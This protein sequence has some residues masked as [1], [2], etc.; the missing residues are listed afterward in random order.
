MFSKFT[1]MLDTKKI[2]NGNDLIKNIYY[3]KRENNVHRENAIT[4]SCLG[5]LMSTNGLELDKWKKDIDRLIREAVKE[6][7]VSHCPLIIGLAESGIVPSALFHQALREQQIQADWV[8]ST[9]RPSHG[10]HFS[11][12]HSH[13]PDHTLP[14][15]CHPPTELW[16]AEDE[17]TTGRTVLRLA[18]SLCETMN[19][20]QVRFFAIADARSASHAD[21][22]RSV[23][24]NH[25]IE[26]SVHTLFHLK[27]RDGDHH[28]NAL[29]L[30]ENA[31]QE[32]RISESEENFENSWHFPRQ[33][34]ALQ[35]QSDVVF[36]DRSLRT[37]G[38]ETGKNGTILAVGEAIDM[39]VRL[40]QA[41]PCLSFRHV[42]LSPWETDGKN[43]FN[44]LDI[45]E[46][47]YLYNYHTLGSPL[48]V[49]NDP[50]DD[51]VGIRIESLLTD[52]GFPVEHL[53]LNS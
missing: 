48:Y 42:T 7:E 41:H 8:C 46:K 4:F 10:I 53:V 50:I 6:R 43:I 29:V 15:P 47:Y 23:L 20:R 34:P 27:Q 44:R 9:R 13:A 12:S 21:Q 32:T 1:L 14:L 19:V 30:V 40:V 24:K 51:D 25:G 17:I 36:P 28:N 52:K 31:L 45:G 3:L 38:M 37:G 26:C 11:E 39:A 22:F 18:L 33:R 5:K 49:L 2:M 35:S 16:F